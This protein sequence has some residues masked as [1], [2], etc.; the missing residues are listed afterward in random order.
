VCR[1]VAPKDDDPLDDSELAYGMIGSLFGVQSAPA[2]AGGGASFTFDKLDASSAAGPVRG[3]LPPGR[4][5]P[6]A[7]KFELPPLVKTGKE[8]LSDIKMPALPLKANLKKK[9]LKEDAV[10]EEGMQGFSVLAEV[11]TPIPDQ[12]GYPI[13]EELKTDTKGKGKAG[14]DQKGHKPIYRRRPR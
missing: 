11:K 14:F 13:G 3:K 7:K 4:G 5:Q 8:I 1:P 6:E 2:K 10:V 9:N 12:L